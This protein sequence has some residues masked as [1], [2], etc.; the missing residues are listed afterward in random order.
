MSDNIAWHSIPE[1]D[2][3]DPP[4]TVTYPPPYP[5]HEEREGGQAGCLVAVGRHVGALLAGWLIPLPAL[6]GTVPGPLAMQ[7]AAAG[8]S[9]PFQW[10]GTALVAVF[11]V[12]VAGTVV[13]AVTGGEWLA[14]L[15]TLF[16]RVVSALGAR[17]L[18]VPVVRRV[19]GFALLAAAWSM[20][21]GA[22]LWAPFQHFL[23]GGN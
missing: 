22:L 9:L 21:T 7:C 16:A 17:L 2:Q 14:A 13:G 11:V 5:A 6:P 3:D 20:F 10:A 23:I 8:V 4:Q 12:L 18:A 15:F 19:F 1:P